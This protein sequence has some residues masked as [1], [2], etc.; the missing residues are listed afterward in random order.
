ME[1]PRERGTVWVFE[2]SALEAELTRRTLAPYARV[3]VFG[4][5]PSLLE[6]ISV[7]TLPDLVLLGWQLPGLGGVE[8]CRI[9]RALHDEITLP[10][11][12][13]TTCGHKQDIVE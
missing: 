4:N 10:L 6:R 1:S 9:I 7:G 13:V 5:G 3:E 8:V 2:D 12:M 11:V